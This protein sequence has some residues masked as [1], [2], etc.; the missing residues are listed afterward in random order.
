MTDC[1]MF[2]DVFSYIAASS[3]PI[4]SFLEFFLPVLRTIFFQ[5]YWLLSH[6]AIVETTDS[7]ERGIDPVAMTIINPRKEYWLSQ[8]S[9]K[10]PPGLKSATLLTELWRLALVY[11]DMYIKNLQHA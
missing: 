4:H 6:I 5:S 1:M 8:G 7:G 10:R 3:A 2:N 11:M 9:N